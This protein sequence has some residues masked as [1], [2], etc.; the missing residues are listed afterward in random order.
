VN[1]LV[2]VTT[3][4]DAEE[5]T[6]EE[7]ADLFIQRWNIELDL[8]S[9]KDVMR[10]MSPEMVENDI[11]IYL[12]AYNLIRGVAAKAH[13][14]QPRLLS[15]KGTLQTMNAFRDALRQAT[16]NERDHLVKEMLRAIARH[17]VGD[18][19]GRVEPRANKRRPKAQRFLMEPRKQ[20]RKRLLQA[21]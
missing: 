3:V 12:L 1:E 10:C 18:R 6:K 15:F 21:A 17:D 8:R 16:P 13:D 11:L 2:L 5:Y 7:A 4:L 14:K 19:P 9:I 20:A